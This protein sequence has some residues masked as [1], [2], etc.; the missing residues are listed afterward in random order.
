MRQVEFARRRLGQLVAE[1]V[2]ARKG[3]F[4]RHEQ[5]HLDYQFCVSFQEI[6]PPECARKGPNG[7]F[8]Y[9]TGHAAGCAINSSARV[10][11]AF[12]SLRGTTASSIPC[13]NKNSLR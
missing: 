6:A 1:R 10:M 13:S 7:M 2:H 9:L 3:C 8:V 11:Y 4:V 5:R 12:R